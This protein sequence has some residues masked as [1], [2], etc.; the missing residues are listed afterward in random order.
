MANVI[1]VT[2]RVYWVGA[3]DHE[4]D[5]F[6]AVWPLPRGVS[7][8]SYLINDDKVALVDTVKGCYLNTLLEKIQSTIGQGKNV[9]YLVVNHMEPDHSGS[10]KILKNIFPDL[11]IVGNKKTMEFVE[12]FYGITD[13]IHVVEDGDTLEL[14]E[15]TLQFFMTPMVHWPETMVTFDTKDNILFS[16]DAFGGFGAVDDGIFDDEADIEYYE[17]EI[18]RYFSNI[19]GRYSAMV[20][21][22]I[23][24]LG[25]LDIAVVAPSHGL[26]WRN[27][28]AHII[29]L[30]NRWSRH[31]T[32]PGVVLVYASM[33]G[34]TRTM[35]DTIGR[36]LAEE[37][38][39]KIRIHDISRT[40]PSFV[41]RDIWRYKGLIM[42]SPTY[43]TQLFP[44]MRNLLCFLE[45]EKMQNRVVGVFGS[46]SW[47]KG[48]VKALHEF[49]Q[50]PGWKLVEP[51]I[52]VKCSANEDEL[53]QCTQLAK[54]MAR[55]V[56]Q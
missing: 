1:P 19:V 48:A 32:E 55:E 31:E 46:Y 44:L 2:D 11:T 12:G 8:N 16:C 35:A 33:Y 37:N 41:I 9:D 56:K 42:G 36:T 29:D 51:V 52:E 18:L 28:P 21:K 13:T 22:A 25:D 5:L 40:H 6:E 17:D 14:G 39:D 34:N 53:A 54:N 23:A 30:Y 20:Q 15:H 3:N 47:S 43:N 38:V 45:N 49:T 10:M 27:N 7:Y 26:V 24:K 4:T 50:K